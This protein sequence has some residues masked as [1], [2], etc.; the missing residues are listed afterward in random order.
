MTQ[1]ADPKGISLPKTKLFVSDGRL[2]RRSSTNQT[3]SEIALNS[4]TH[5]SVRMETDWPVIILPIGLFAIG[6]AC[7]WLVSSPTIGWLLCIGL[8]VVGLLSLLGLKRPLITVQTQDGQMT[9]EVKDTFPDAEA[10]TLS[11][12]QQ[13]KGRMVS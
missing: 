11:L 4:I 5:I 3:V 8:S 13:I 6:A 10:F 2:I 1:E 7:K 12:K 9:F